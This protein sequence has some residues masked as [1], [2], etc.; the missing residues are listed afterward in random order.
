MAIDMG[1]VKVHPGFIAFK[2]SNTKPDTTSDTQAKD[3]IKDE[4]ETKQDS[5]LADKKAKITK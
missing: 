5:Q 3:V 1:K 2:G 4:I